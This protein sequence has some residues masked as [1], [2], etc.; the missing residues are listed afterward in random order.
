MA[1]FTDGAPVYGD[2]GISFDYKGARFLFAS[3]E[4]RD[5]F[6]GDP[7][8]YAPQYGGYCAYA[9]AQGAFA[10]SVPEAWTIRDGRLY[11]NFSTGV[12]ALWLRSPD[13]YIADANGSGHTVQVTRCE[14]CQGAMARRHRSSMDGMIERRIA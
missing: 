10:T 7:A 8:K 2:P 3:E 9:M 6:A 13:A 12:R 1:Y 11:L 14:L 5:L 4:H